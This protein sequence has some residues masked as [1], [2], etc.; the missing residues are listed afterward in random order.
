MLVIIVRHRQNI[1]RENKI[2]LFMA[3]RL[4]AIADSP[5]LKGDFV[6]YISNIRVS[7]L[8]G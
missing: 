8:I 5:I 6:C 2:I 7:L 1:A 4:S 3:N